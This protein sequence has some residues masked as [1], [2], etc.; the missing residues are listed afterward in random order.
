MRQPAA[1]VQTGARN[2]DNQK[3]LSLLG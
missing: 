1:S 3:Q 2:R